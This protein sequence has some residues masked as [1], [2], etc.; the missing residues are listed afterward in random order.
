MVFAGYKIHIVVTGAA[1]RPARLG[2]PVCRLAGCAIMT[3]FAGPKIL[4]IRD[5]REVRNALLESNNLIR[6]PGNDTRKVRP[7]MNLV[8]HYFEIDRVPRIRVYR[9][10]RMA[11]DTARDIAPL[12]TVSLQRVGA[13]VARLRPDHV[14]HHSDRTSVGHP[15]ILGIR[16]LSPK[17]EFRQISL[18]IESDGVRHRSIEVRR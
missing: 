17:I 11:G 5:M 13:L 9:L 2:E 15:G 18:P 4:G 14:S 10:R 8:D 3:G 1:G 7:R 12:S 6:C 16:H